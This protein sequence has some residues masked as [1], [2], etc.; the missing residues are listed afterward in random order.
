M[1]DVTITATAVQKTANTKTQTGIAGGTIT[2]GM[3]VY[4]DATDSRHLKP[5]DAVTAAKANVAGIALHGAADGQPLTY[6]Y[7]GDVTMDGLTAAE[8]YVLS[9]SADSGAI[10][11]AA[12]LTQDDYVTLMGVAKAAT[13]LSLAMNVTGI[14]HP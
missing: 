4:H 14:Q 3:V 8:V 13:T 11:P 6:A 10:A 2:A 9:A 7:A 12:D 1:A 5:G